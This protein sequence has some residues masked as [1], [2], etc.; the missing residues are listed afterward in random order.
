MA[1][2]AL[3]PIN[4]DALRLSGIARFFLATI[5]LAMAC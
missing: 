2:Q 5:K 3:T 4:P 1:H